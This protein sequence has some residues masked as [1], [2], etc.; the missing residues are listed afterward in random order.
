MEKGLLVVELTHVYVDHDRD[1]GQH[2]P[3]P[4]LQL[5]T[6]MGDGL[7]R[8]VHGDSQDERA[9]D[10]GRDVVRLGAVYVWIGPHLVWTRAMA[11]Y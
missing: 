6:D 5:L 8:D 1:R 9:H 11:L 3:A 4:D 10:D 2:R 7:V